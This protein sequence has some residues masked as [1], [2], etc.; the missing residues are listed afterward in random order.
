MREHLA[1]AWAWLKKYWPVL[2]AALGAVLAIVLMRGGKSGIEDEVADELDETATET[3]AAVEK[4]EDVVHELEKKEVA[5]DTREEVEVEAALN[6]P[7]KPVGDD[8]SLPELDALDDI[9]KDS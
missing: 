1:A 2:V 8:G 6:D 7:L 5:I 3:E 9:L 4:H